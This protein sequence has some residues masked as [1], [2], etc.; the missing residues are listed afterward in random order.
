MSQRA[1]MIGYGSI[2]QR[3][4]RVLE[5]LGYEVTVVSQRGVGDGRAVYR[6]IPARRLDE[7]G[8]AVVANGTVRHAIS[9]AELAQMGFRGRVLV[10]KPMFA[11][12]TAL[13][14]HDFERS[15]VGYNLRFHTAVKALRQAIADRAVQMAHLYVG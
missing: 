1:L 4:T 10:E 13:P 2:G 9:L 12:P 15:G 11:A 5:A 6:D 8:Y 3:H 14:Q 7:F